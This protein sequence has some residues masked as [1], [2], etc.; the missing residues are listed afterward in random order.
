MRFDNNGRALPEAVSSVTLRAQYSGADLG[1]QDIELRRDASGAYVADG[2]VLSLQGGWQFDV[3]V[4]SPGV[5]DTQAG[6][7]L[8]IAPAGEIGIALPQQSTALLASGW[9]VVLLALA[10]LVVAEVFW[11]STRSG[12]IANWSGTALVAAGV[13]MVYGVGHFHQG[14]PPPIGGPVNPIM[15]SEES[16]ALGRSLYALHCVTCHGP[17]GLGDGPAGVGLNPP[18]AS[19]PSH[20]PLHS[21]GELYAFVEAGFPGSAMPAFRGT[22]T[23]EQVW[24]LVNYLRALAT[25]T[26]RP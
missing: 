26:T 17:S 13:L 24:N 3:G 18:P 16:V 25:P 8:P 14:A 21:D 7:R 11:K 9:Q 6:M 12:Q 2:V 4:S 1:A 20:V 23:D 5:F 10:V 22:L 19:L 15:T